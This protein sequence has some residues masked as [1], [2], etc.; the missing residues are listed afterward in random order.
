MTQHIEEARKL[1]PVAWGAWSDFEQKVIAA[2]TDKMK[3]DTYDGHGDISIHPLVRLS[4]AQAALAASEE[5]GRSE[6]RERCAI[7]PAGLGVETE[8]LQAHMVVY[9]TYDGKLF[10]SKDRVL[11]YCTDRP[12][13]LGNMGWVKK[14]FHDYP[15]EEPA[16]T[17]EPTP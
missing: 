7:K 1:E 12:Y 6:E 11:E 15:C 2:T 8:S 14:Q 9:Q 4:D 16:I 3:A 13:A 5:R 17:K 10:L